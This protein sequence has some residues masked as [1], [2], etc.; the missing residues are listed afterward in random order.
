MRVIFS[1]AALSLS[2][3]AAA[4]PLPRSSSPFPL[5]DG[6]PTPTRPNCNRSSSGPLAP[7]P[8][9]IAFNELFE[10]A[11]FDSLIHN[12]TTNVSG[13]EVKNAK[14]RELLL[15]ALE[16]AKAQEEL[17]ALNANNALQAFTGQPIQPCRYKFPS[18]DLDS[19]ITLAGTFTSVVLGTL[20]DV[21]QV[22]A[23]NGDVGLTRAVASVVG[24]EGEQE[25]FFRQLQGKVPNELPFLT[26]STRDFA[27]NALNQTFIVPGSCPNI[28]VIQG[29]KVFEPLTL[30]SKPEAK[31]EPIQFSFETTDTTK[32]MEGLKLVYVNQQN[33]P[34]VEDFTVVKTEGSTVTIE[35]T[36]PYDENELNG[37]T[38]T[39]VVEGASGSGSNFTDAQAVADATK[40]GPALIIVN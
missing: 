19:A 17:H 31:T 2:Y 15:K 33:L 23:K 27:I 4:S 35:A 1:V 20:Q 12:I 38:I 29:L 7:C 21:I 5:K 28:Q 6:F 32:N 26:T 37:L 14:S 40:F 9:L 11:F 24:Q 16:A 34:I 22:F 36:F 3:L 39:T 25:G 30:L 10:V 13:F 18:T 8:T